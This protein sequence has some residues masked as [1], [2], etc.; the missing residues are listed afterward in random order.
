MILQEK[1]FKPVKVIIHTFLIPMSISEPLNDLKKR[2]YQLEFRR[3]ATC[4]YCIGLNSWIAPDSFI[5]DE[6]YHFEDVSNMYG[7]R[8]LYAI[9]SLQGLKGFL[10]DT[11]L[12]Y[13]DNISPEMAYKLKLEYALPR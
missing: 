4:L 5:V 3:E 9:S 11:C 8:T 10:V 13:E 6:F 2:G 7:D 12:V 1:Q